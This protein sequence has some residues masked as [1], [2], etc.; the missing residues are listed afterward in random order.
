ME[1]MIND[2]IRI[3]NSSYKHIEQ[4]Q[5][6]VRTKNDK[7]FSLDCTLQKTQVSTFASCLVVRQ[8]MI[9]S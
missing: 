5:R 1:A 6:Q 9:P 8:T 7:K 4:T 2:L 3:R